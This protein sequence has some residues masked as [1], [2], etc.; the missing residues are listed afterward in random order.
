MAEGVPPPAAGEHGEKYA[1]SAAVR[2]VAGSPS[3]ADSKA[4]PA[5]YRLSSPY[6]AELLVGAW[7][8][9]TR[10]LDPAKLQV[11]N[12]DGSW[13]VE[14]ADSGGTMTVKEKDMKP[15]T[16]EQRATVEGI[17]AEKAEEPAE[18]VESSRKGE[19]SPEME[20]FCTLGFLARTMSADDVVSYMQRVSKQLTRMHNNTAISASGLRA[21]CSKSS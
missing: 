10:K 2:T 3:S 17:Q 4:V 9:V 6:R 20:E 11:D 15:L 13:Q 21:E 19:A 16:L 18:T 5:R 8:Q 1:G 12:G 14:Y 7:V